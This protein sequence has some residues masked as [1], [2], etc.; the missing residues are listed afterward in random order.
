MGGFI[1]S[2]HGLFLF[3]KF[4]STTA[5]HTSEGDGWKLPW[6]VNVEDVFIKM[7]TKIL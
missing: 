2:R 5:T 4:L 3:L 6:G 1:I 7:K